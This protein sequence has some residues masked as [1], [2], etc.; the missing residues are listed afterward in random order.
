MSVAYIS[1]QCIHNN[2]HSMRV[3]EKLKNKICNAQNRRSDEIAN[4]LFEIYNNTVMPN[5]K[6]KFQTASDMEI[7]TICTYPSSNYASPYWKSFLPCY[8]KIPRIDLP[9]P[10]SDQKS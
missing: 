2:D 1:K 9:S 4:I 8:E 5:L 6:Q 3:F 7:S 10:K